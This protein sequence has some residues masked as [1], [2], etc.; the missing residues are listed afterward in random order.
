M[1]D[2]QTDPDIPLRKN[3]RSKARPKARFG[4]CAKLVDGLAI[5]KPASPLTK[6]MERDNNWNQENHP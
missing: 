3:F 5:G 1:N 6:P 4:L 2:L